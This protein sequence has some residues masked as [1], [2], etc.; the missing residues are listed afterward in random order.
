MSFKSIL[1][2]VGGFF[3]NFFTKAPQVVDDAFT[4]AD[5]VVNILKTLETSVTAQTIEAVVEGFAPGLSNTVFG[6]LNTFFTDF[7]FVEKGVEG[8]VSAVSAIG[9]AAVNKLT[10][11]SK[12]LALGNVASI[13]GHAISGGNSTLQQAMAVNQVVHD[14]TVL[15]LPFGTVDSQTTPLNPALTPAPPLPT[16]T[17]EPQS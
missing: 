2:S 12:T 4:A 11:D 9:L 13:V 10:G 15:S 8:A 6:A 14:P 3:T 5:K 1:S 16:T 17:T 7:G